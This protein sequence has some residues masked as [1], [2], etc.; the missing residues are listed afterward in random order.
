MNTTL[1]LAICC[2]LAVYTLCSILYHALRWRTQRTSR[3]LDATPAQSLSSQAASPEPDDAGAALTIDPVL[4]RVVDAWQYTFDVIVDPVLVLDSDLKIV[5]GNRAAHQLLAATGESIAGHPC[6]QLFA[7][8]GQVCPG[9]P[10]Q[11]VFQEKTPHCQEISHGYLGKIFMVSYSPLFNGDRVVGY[12]LSP[13]DISHQ[14]NLEKRL[15]HAHK[16][17]S[18]ATLAG[19]IAHDFNNILG[20]VLGNAD[21]LLYRLRAGA[22]EASGASPVVTQSEITEHLQAIKR[23]GIR[24]KILVGQ[25]LTFS[26]Q[27]THQRCPLLIAPVV[28]ESC[29][30]L[31]STL[32]AT[33][34]LKVAVPEGIGMIH[35][36]SGQIQQVIMHLCTNAAQSLPNETGVIEVSLREIVV[37]RVEQLRYPDLDLGH[38][39][40][41]TVADTGRG[42]PPETLQRI[43]DPFYTTKEVGQGTGMGLAVLHGIIA[44][45]DGVIDV[46]SA[47]DK[48]TV[49]TVF[50]P[51][52]PD[53]GGG[54][55]KQEH[56]A[57]GVP[58]GTGTILFVD[59]EEDIVTMRTRMLSMLGYRVLPATSPE[60]ALS[61][62]TKGEEQVDLLITDHTMPRMTGLQLADQAHA[63]RADLPIILC[64]GYSE[65]LT[66]EEAQ[67]HW[68][69]RFLA[70]PVDMRLLAIAVHEILAGRKRE[71]G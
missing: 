19:G 15:L 69:Q 49:F 11:K 23:A 70:K 21:L 24:A 58:H 3:T 28:K 41:L 14:R 44:A 62:L 56:G 46:S 61:I 38:Y 25:I 37:G 64:S 27:S 67:R 51:R 13:K 55:G 7:A 36:D 16:L 39:A 5:K 8:S 40:V 57:Q 65:I 66:M 45:H 1:L 35:A 63:L 6:H 33:I 47:V 2:L 53:E 31:R 32:P 48:G 26:S 30:L 10:T 59:D 22:Q 71:G 68:I 20:A 43:F 17:E 12:V 52:L 60:Q 42:M 50:F 54:E 34:E 29:R 4:Q 9:C 18:I